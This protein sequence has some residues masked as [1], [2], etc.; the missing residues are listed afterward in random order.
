MSLCELSQSEA[1]DVIERSESGGDF[2]SYVFGIQP[3]IDPAKAPLVLSLPGAFYE[4]TESDVHRFYTPA[5]AF[6][7]RICGPLTT[8]F[9]T[10]RHF[11]FRPYG[12]GASAVDGFISG[13]FIPGLCVLNPVAAVGVCIGAL[14]EL[15]LGF[16]F[17]VKALV[18]A[19][20]GETA[21]AK[22][23]AWDGLSRLMLSPVLALL[24]IISMPIEMI[25][26]FTRSISTLINFVKDRMDAVPLKSPAPD[27]NFS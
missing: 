15:V 17:A 4:G 18:H 20:K 24:S 9:S 7:R 8:C 10:P 21:M 14:I 1:R 11:F 12:S 6:N 3:K 16:A 23:Y 22:Q 2:A 27:M 13:L 26:F 25:R 5:D 19:V